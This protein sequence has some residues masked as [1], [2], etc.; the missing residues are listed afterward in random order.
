MEF[1]II[2][3]WCNEFV[4]QSCDGRHDPWID[5]EYYDTFAAAAESLNK[6]GLDVVLATG[7]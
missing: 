4:V 2:Q 7:E 6:L 1:R 5:V 3:R